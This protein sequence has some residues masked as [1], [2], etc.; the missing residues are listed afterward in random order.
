MKTS[1]AICTYNGEQFLNQQIDSILNQTHPVDEIIVCDDRSTD[2]TISILNSY[3]EKYPDLFKIYVNEK[4]LRSVKNFEKALSLC[5]NEIILLSDQDDIWIKEKVEKYLVHFE[6]R[7]DISV[8]ASN[9]FGIDDNGNLLDIISVWDII[10]YLKKAEKKIDYY[11]IICFSGNIATGATMAIK[12]DFL[13]KTFP[14]PEIPEFHHD[15]WIALIAA[16]EKKFDFIDDKTFYYR[17]HT[18]QQVGGV[19]FENTHKKKDVLIRFFSLDFIDT[20][21]SNYK[22]ILKRIS[23]SHNKHKNLLEKSKTNNEIF[24][25]SLNNFRK[26]FHEYKQSM[27]ERYPI[28]Y[29]ILTIFDNINDKRQL[30]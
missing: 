30:K 1:V 20:S 10:S 7:P 23:S 27:R 5:N 28:R 14:F 6:K 22:H 11:E 9:G 16:S 19:F 21:F 12:K 24:I 29:F 18:N 8:I 4:N 17:Q 26:L 3:K 15:E 13:Q 2:S 25:K